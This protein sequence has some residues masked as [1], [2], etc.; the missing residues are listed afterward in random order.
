MIADWNTKLLDFPGYHFLQTK[1][2]AAF[3]CSYGWESEFLYNMNTEKKSA[4]LILTRRRAF[5]HPRIFAEVKYC[6]RGPLLNWSHT[7]AADHMLTSLEE[8]AKRR[9]VIFIKIDPEVSTDHSGLNGLIQNERIGNLTQELLSTRGWKYS[10]DQI[11]FKNSVILDIHPDTE[12]LL[13]SMKQKTRYN[14]RLAEKRGILVKKAKE[15]E[16][17]VLFQMYSETSIRDGFVIRNEEYY[18]QMWKGFMRN[19]FAHPFLAFYEGIPIAGLIMFIMGSKAWYF[20]GM[21]RNMHRDRMP[22]Y[23]LQ[24]EAIKYAKQKGCGLYDLWGAPD[25]LDE[26]SPMWGVYR[27]KE[28]LGG[29]LVQWIGA[30]DFSCRP[31]LYRFYT[32]IMPAILEG[33]RRRSKTKKQLAL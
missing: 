25:H 19:G 21:S 12:I 22:T 5:L 16:L 15:E 29:K 26:N 20:F 6:P 27:F 32:K 13:Q 4:C 23:L 17:P 9:N 2:W 28:G 14:I 10:S 30:W 1:D 3:K 24:W 7:D 11:Q 8:I 33:L 18:I 31:S